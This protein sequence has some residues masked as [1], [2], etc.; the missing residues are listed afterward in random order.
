MKQFEES[1]TTKDFLFIIDFALNALR[2]KYDM[3]DSHPMMLSFQNLKDKI[4][5]EKLD[6]RLVSRED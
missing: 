2:V 1:Q 5:K 4:K 6:I 3:K